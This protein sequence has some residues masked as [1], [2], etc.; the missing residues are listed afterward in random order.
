MNMRQAMTWKHLR[1]AGYAPPVDLSYRD[2]MAQVSAALSALTPAA[3]QKMTYEE[4]LEWADEDTLAEWIALPDENVGV[5]AMTSPASDKHQD[6]SGFLGSVL[7]TFVETHHLGVVRSA[8]FQMKLEHGR[9][10]DLLFIAT[11]HLDRL[12]KT[13]LDG[14]ADLV[15]EIISPESISRDRGVKFYEYARGGV[16]EYWLID[17][18]MQWAEFYQLYGQ[19]YQL[20]TEGGAG[21]CTSAVLPDFWL[22]IEWLWQ[23]PLPPVLDIARALKLIQ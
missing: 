14:P 19:R 22:H 12:Q 11:E 3:P 2:I 15:I 1:L 21:K 18:E 5:V 23:D 4:F 16:P 13:Y 17:P 20:V 9:E 6:L 8:P 10:P 7:R